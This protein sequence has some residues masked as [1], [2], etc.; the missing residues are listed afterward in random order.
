MRN[1]NHNHN[2]N[3]NQNFKA[4]LL[5]LLVVLSPM[6]LAEP[7]PEN[8]PLS[9]LSLKNKTQLNPAT[10][11]GGQPTQADIAKL[12]SIG[13]TTVIN[14]RGLGEFEQFDEQALAEENQLNYV[15]IP[16]A[17]ADDLTIENA[18]KLADIMQKADG[19]VLI[20]CASGNRVGALLAIKAYSIDKLP[21]EESMALGKA[22]GM[23]RLSGKVEALL[24]KSK[25]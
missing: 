5:S 14:L 16:I 10:I 7:T 12:S 13:V 9:Q 18:T 20:H 23:T 24:A 1:H 8:T 22:A 19:K 4:L 17:S 6:V 11:T 21:I 2:H 3:Q 25:Q 15:A